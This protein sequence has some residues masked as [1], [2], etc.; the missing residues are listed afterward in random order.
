VNRPADKYDRDYFDKW[1]RNPRFRVKSAGDLARQVA[2]VVSA[3]EHIL[4]RAVRTVLDVGCGEGNWLAPLRRLRPRVQYTGV[5]ASEYAV[6]RFGQSRNIRLG[7]IDD[8]DRLKLRKDYD[9]IL[10]VGMLNYLEPAQLQTGLGHLYDRAH[11]LVYLELFTS[12]DHGVFG[13]TRGTRLRSAAWYR[14][15]IRDARFLSCGL[16]CY[17]P[18]WLREHTAVMERCD[19]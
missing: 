17:V 11:G 15:R 2:F 6:A 1:Y 12:T 7:T 8:L 19:R 16:H 5:D 9:V 14:A 4:G 3:A 18:D 10:C 13:D